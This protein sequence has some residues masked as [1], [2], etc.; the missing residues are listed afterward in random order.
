MVD[1]NGDLQFCAQLVVTENKD[2]QQIDEESV[3]SHKIAPG[4]TSYPINYLFDRHV[5]EL[6]FIKLFGGKIMKINTN[7]AKSFKFNRF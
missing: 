7:Y 6:S 4:E 5:E 1:Q 3:K 2:D